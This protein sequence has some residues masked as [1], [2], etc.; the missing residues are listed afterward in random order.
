MRIRDALRARLDARR[1]A[2]RA[3]LAIV[4][5]LSALLAAAPPAAAARQVS[6]GFFGVVID[7][8][9]IR[10][11]PAATLDGQMALMARSGVESIR[12]NFFWP[13]FQP[14]RHRFS[15]Q[16]T[17]QIV[18]MAA[19]HGLEVLPVVEYTPAWASGRSNIAY[20]PR[21]VATFAN[22]MKALVHR[23]GPRGSFWRGRA[24]PPFDPIRAWQI[25]NE[26]E[27]SW[28]WKTLPWARHY[29]ALLKAAYRAVHQADHHAKVVTA[30][31]VGVGPT[32]ETPWSEMASLYQ[33]GLRRYFDIVAVNPYTGSPSVSGSV[34]QSM[35]IVSFV[36]D[37]MNRYGDARKP[38]W[39][40]E[41][42]WTAALGK[43]H[44]GEYVDIETTPQGQAQRLQLYMDVAA[45]QHP[46]GLQRIF[47]YTWA[48]LYY[49]TY[50]FGG[51]AT[52]QFAGLVKW[53]G[54]GGFQPLALLGAY[55][56]KALAYEGCRTKSSAGR[57]G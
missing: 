52:F 16:G 3:P 29:G 57:C 46:Y 54:G 24:H 47:W 53:D 44:P 18:A 48:S 11:A 36:R 28:D 32:G 33:L 1:E 39:A 7:P 9:V 40:T 38:I 8:Y 41:V 4:L 43:L 14:A 13:N 26:P 20:A 34:A 12:V 55:A 22:A 56:A 51:A 49:H 5:A 23:Y 50:A 21:N 45:R 31:W 25:W 19:R 2:L 42:T 17:D 35:K 27:G 15:W 6:H 10:N 30:A 37:V